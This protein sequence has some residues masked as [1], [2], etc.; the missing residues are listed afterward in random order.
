LDIPIKQKEDNKKKT[1]ELKN[2]LTS[3]GKKGSGFGYMHV[4]IGPYHKYESDPYDA[5]IVSER[6]SVD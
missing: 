4:T 5:S 1:P 2:F 3:P 6:V